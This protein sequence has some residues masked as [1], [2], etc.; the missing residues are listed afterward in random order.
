MDGVLQIWI[1]I[2]QT[3]S[4]VC[5]VQCVM[6]P[7][8]VNAS[9]NFINLYAISGLQCQCFEG[10]SKS[11]THSFI[12]QMLICRS[13]YALLYKGMKAYKSLSNPDDLRLFR[14]DLNMKRLSNSM[15]RLSCPGYDFDKKEL[16]ECI[17]ELVRVG[18]KL[19]SMLNMYLN[20]KNY[21]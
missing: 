5:M 1:H 10:K 14:P 18:K 17:A 3:S 6:L 16:I 8:H 15:H 4:V 9:H 13:T 11:N 12:L 7:C 19:T 20:T 2:L 21:N